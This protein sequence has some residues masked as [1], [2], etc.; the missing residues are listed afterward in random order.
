M[1]HDDMPQQ[2]AGGSTAA[3]NDHRPDEQTPRKRPSK[4]A[5]KRARD[6]ASGPALTEPVVV[7]ASA[8]YMHGRPLRIYVTLFA[9]ALAGYTLHNSGIS[10]IIMPNHIQDL[11]FQLYFTGGDSGVD[12]QQLDELKRSVAA[13]T[14]TA[15]ADQTRLLGLLG[16]FETTRATAAGLLS[17]LSVILVAVISPVVGVLSDRTRSRFGRRAPW[18]LFGATIG[19]VLTAL[20]PLAPSLTVLIAGWMLI[21]LTTSIAQQSVNTTLADRVPEDQRG[22]AS[23][24]GSTGNFIGGLVGSIGASVLYPVLG[25]GLYVVF[26]VVLVVSFA[27]FVVLVRDRSSVTLH[28]P[29]TTGKQT[30]AGFLVPLRSP[31]F[32][33]VWIARA[34]LFFGYTIPASLSFFMLQSYIEPAL[35]QAEATAIIPILSLAGVP[36]VI[37]GIAVAGRLSDKAGRRK[38]FVVGAS[39]LM[40]VSLFIPFFFPT[41]AGL[42]AQA[43]LAAL[44]FGAFLPVDQALFVDVLPD[45]EK[46]AGRDLGI[47]GIATNVG[48]AAGPLLAAQIVALT[49]GYALLWPVA[50]VLVVGAALAMIPVK[51][52]R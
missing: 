44:A 12:L 4:R 43:I 48:Q 21:T 23:S 40:A 29:K 30:L 31:D 28:V 17:T 3:E 46:N 15:T 34:L 10:G 11:A 26:A 49:G 36:G 5:E 39:V 50:G 32:R 52:A 7:G 22:G 41:L 14:A 2:P 19:A 1:S 45:R 9:T 47:A 33:W 37:I 8:K 38:P 24:A 27:M 13:G 20:L 51:G 6:A 42:F 18:I 16:Q 25:L 35:S